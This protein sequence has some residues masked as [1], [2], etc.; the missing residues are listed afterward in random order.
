M[1]LFF[2]VA[3]LVIL[4]KSPFRFLRCAGFRFDV[5]VTIAG[6]LNYIGL[7]GY[8]LAADDNRQEFR[9][10][11]ARCFL[12]DGHFETTGFLQHIA[13]HP[14]GPESRFGLVRGS[15]GERRSGEATHPGAE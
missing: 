10:V 13:A 12:A 5:A 8:V 6:L 2:V 15:L 1:L 7:V 11:S 14:V 3:L 4:A 9:L